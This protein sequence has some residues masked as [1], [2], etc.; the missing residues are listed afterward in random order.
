MVTR[1][2]DCHSARMRVRW[3]QTLE[4]IHFAGATSIPGPS[5]G[6]ARPD[7]CRGMT[8]DVVGDYRVAS[9]PLVRGARSQVPDGKHHAY[10][11]QAKT[12]VCGFGLGE[13]QRFSGLRFIASPPSAR[14]SM[15][16]RIVRAAAR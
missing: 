5:G 16:D 9:Y 7:G 8:A 12:T 3:G 6:P 15:C 14:C 1:S 2:R 4:G 10:L 11:E 13:M